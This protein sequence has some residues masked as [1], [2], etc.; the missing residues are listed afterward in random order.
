MNEEYIQNSF[1]N[2]FGVQVK[3]FDICYTENTLFPKIETLEKPIIIGV[4]INEIKLSPQYLLF[5]VKTLSNY[6]RDN[7]KFGIY[8]D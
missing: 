8:S 1:V 5:P 4:G 6:W 3:I 7:L 2:Q